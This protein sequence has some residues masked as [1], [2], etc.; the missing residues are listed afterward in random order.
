M[1]K[2]GVDS[3]L[4]PNFSLPKICL[5]HMRWMSSIVQGTP[6]CDDS[7]MNLFS[8]LPCHTFSPLCLRTFHSDPALFKTL[9]AQKHFFFRQPFILIS[10]YDGISC[11]QDNAQIK[12]SNDIYIFNIKNQRTTNASGLEGPRSWQDEVFF[13]A[14]LI[15][16]VQ[17]FSLGISGSRFH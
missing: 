4:A 7:D 6:G 17:L 9:C 5:Q 1:R 8:F 2:Q 14:N 10:I 16:C 3:P 15:F 13:W 12:N 11:K